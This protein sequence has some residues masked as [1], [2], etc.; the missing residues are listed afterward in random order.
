ML[1]AVKR[2]AVAAITAL[3]V[4]A[5]M[6]APA[7]AFGDN[8]RNF[9]QGAA[10]ALIIKQIYDNSRYNRAPQQYSAAPRYQ[11]APQPQYYA[12]P[13]P[14]YYPQPQP[15]YR[16]PAPVAS[17]S[18]YQT[19]AA[20]AFNSYSWSQRAAIQRRLAQQGYYRSGIDGSFGPGT[21]AAISAYARDTGASRALQTR[22]AAYGLYDSLI[23]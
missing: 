8:E 11:P 12:A 10:A 19:P 21:Y 1:P 13:Q 6:A 23:Y 5:T 15:Q 4:A 17:S 18:I 16:H 9:V 2:T 14:R 3:A 22:Q 20:Q 7:H